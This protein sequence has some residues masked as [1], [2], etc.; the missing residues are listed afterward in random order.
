LRADGGLGEEAHEAEAGAGSLLEGLLAPL[1][2]GY[3]RRHVDLVERGEHRRSLLGLHE[4]LGDGLPAARD[5]HPLLQVGPAVLG[6]GLRGRLLRLA[7]CR[8]FCRLLGGR[9]RTGAALL[10]D[11]ALHVVAGYA[12]AGAGTLDLGQL[13]PV[14]FGQLAH[15]GR[16][17]TAAVLPVPVRLLG[18]RLGLGLRL[19]LGL[20]LDRLFAGS[21][22][23]RSFRLFRLGRGAVALAKS[24]DHLAD[25]D[26]VAL[27][28]RYGLEDA[29]VLG[30]DLE[31]DL[32]GL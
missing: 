3:D 7:V 17:A 25:G 26:G 27:G 15:G 28:L 16:G 18:G 31:G 13:N 4:P 6:G 12:P 19:R 14:L 9:G 24:A 32:V 1:A 29:V 22:F 5:P 8:R 23:L 20:L 10:A 11:Q 30:F 2:Q 21:F